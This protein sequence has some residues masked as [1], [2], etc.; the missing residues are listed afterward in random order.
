M[1]YFR[2]SFRFN[3]SNYADF[4]LICKNGK[5]YNNDD[6]S[7]WKMM[8]LY[9]FGWGQENG[10]YRLPVGDFDFLIHLVLYSND[11]EDSYGAAAYINELLCLD[12]KTFLLDYIKEKHSKDE[13]RK[14]KDLFDLSNPLNR[15]FVVS[16][17][18][19]EIINE[20]NDWKKISNYFA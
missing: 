4:G 15:T 1:K 19:D 8:K 10:F 13:I 14:L 11:E 17:T 9:D 20:S 3:K 7:E 5:F 6:N 18:L 12:L 16:M 2:M